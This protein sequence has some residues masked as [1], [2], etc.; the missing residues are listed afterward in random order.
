MSLSGVP[1]PRA[2]PPCA[3]PPAGGGGAEDEERGYGV[4]QPAC[5]R[6]QSLEDCLP[7]N[8]KDSA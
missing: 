7:L 6:F 2:T 5:H 3:T 4:G 8:S 1:P